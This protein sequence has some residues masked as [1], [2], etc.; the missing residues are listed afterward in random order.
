MCA[1]SYGPGAGLSHWARGGLRNARL[2]GSISR[3]T[4]LFFASLTL[5]QRKLVLVVRRLIFAEI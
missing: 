4:T 1:G 5:V 3:K 2:G